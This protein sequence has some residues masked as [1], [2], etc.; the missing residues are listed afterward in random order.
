MS[1]AASLK[2]IRLKTLT[3]LFLTRGPILYESD[4]REDFNAVLAQSLSF[5]T[6]SINHLLHVRRVSPPSTTLLTADQIAPPTPR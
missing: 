6:K 3:G 2:K 1:Y 4:L 5:S